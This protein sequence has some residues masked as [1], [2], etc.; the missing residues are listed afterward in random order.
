MAI[1]IT[2]DKKQAAPSGLIPL[3]RGDDWK[4]QAQIIEKYARYSAPM[5]LTGCAATAFFEADPSGVVTTVANIS[6]PEAGKLEIDIPASASPSCALNENGT[7]I[8]MIIDHP[9]L[10]TITADSELPNLEIKDRGFVEP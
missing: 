3:K 1:Y 9:A 4:L 10:G 8:Y 7:S 5:D 2:F 6:L